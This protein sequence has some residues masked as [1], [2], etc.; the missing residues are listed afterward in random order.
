ML[1]VKLIYSSPQ[2]Y[3]NDNTINDK[4]P[5]SFYIK[6][7]QISPKL[8]SEPHFEVRTAPIQCD[9]PPRKVCVQHLFVL[10]RGL[11]TTMAGTELAKTVLYTVNHLLQQEKYK[12]ALAVV[13][14]FRNG[15]V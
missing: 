11:P 4:T 9:T 6:I 8:I 2:T 1:W 12:A 10:Y 5:I 13:K 7:H 15:A 14:G 3:N